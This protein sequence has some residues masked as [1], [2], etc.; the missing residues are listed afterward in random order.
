[1]YKRLVAVDPANQATVRTVL[2]LYLKINRLAN[3]RNAYN[4]LILISSYEKLSE[5]LLSLK[6]NACLS[7][8]QIPHQRHC[9]LGI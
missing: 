8:L 9:H 2:K 3:Q 5:L 4:L 7:L 1:L 6:I